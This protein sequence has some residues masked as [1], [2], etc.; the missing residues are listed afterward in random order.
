MVN[1]ILNNVIDA[2]NNYKFCIE[3]ICFDK[4]INKQVKMISQLT[5]FQSEEEAILNF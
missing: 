2:L 1:F 3:I 4:F 5:P